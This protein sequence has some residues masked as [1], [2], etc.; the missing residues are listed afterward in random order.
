MYTH[1]RE[2]CRNDKKRIQIV[3]RDSKKLQH[4]T[5]P[6]NTKRV[7]VSNRKSWKS[8]GKLNTS[9]IIDKL[10]KEKNK[11]NSLRAQRLGEAKR[12]VN[13]QRTRVNWE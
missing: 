13:E 10:L 5:T 11:S 2:E 1:R 6:E 3:K 12:I 9:K 8:K 4:I 7:R